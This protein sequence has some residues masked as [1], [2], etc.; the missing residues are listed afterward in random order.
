MKDNQRMTEP[1][2]VE[3]NEPSTIRRLVDD[4]ALA[5]RI[6]TA[7]IPM[8]EM[9]YKYKGCLPRAEWEQ[10]MTRKLVDQPYDAL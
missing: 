8:Q 4:P 2:M 1:T 9:C 3:E 6:T 10:N 5:S 7:L